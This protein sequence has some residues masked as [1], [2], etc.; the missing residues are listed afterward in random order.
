MDRL[1]VATVT[2]SG[3]KP[4]R[5]RYP[6]DPASAASPAFVCKTTPPEDCPPGSH[7]AEPVLTSVAVT[8][9]ALPAGT[10]T[11]PPTV[12]ASWP[13]LMPRWV[14]AWAYPVGAFFY[15]L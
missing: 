6:S 7:V 4:V 8:W 1:P 3:P 11:C 9:H 12:T 14:G 13:K 2:A 5:C 10:G 15:R